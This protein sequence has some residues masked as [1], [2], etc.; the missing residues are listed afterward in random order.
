[1]RLQWLVSSSLAKEKL[2][3]PKRT[4]AGWERLQR[5]LFAHT[6]SVTHSGQQ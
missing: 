3:S 6:R 4:E 2:V 5:A 1:M